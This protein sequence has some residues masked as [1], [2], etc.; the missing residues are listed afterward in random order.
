[1]MSPFIVIA[2]NVVLSLVIIGFSI[3]LY[4]K[5]IPINRIYGFRTKKTRSSQEI[6]YAA[7]CY[8]AK[9]MLL[10]GTLHLIISVG[11][12]FCTHLDWFRIEV[13][14]FFPYLYLIPLL[15]S[16]VKLSKM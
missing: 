8:A 10:F 1:M 4:L 7:N 13:F 5:R 6:W 11:A 2:A 16:L 12:L 9:Q 15:L 14:Y 3:P